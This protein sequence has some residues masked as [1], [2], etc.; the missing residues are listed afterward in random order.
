MRLDALWPI[1]Y[2]AAGPASMTS[3]TISVFRV[4]SVIYALV[5]V[6]VSSWPVIKIPDLGVSWGDKIAHFSQY[7]V[8]A[9][10]VAGGWARQGGW[11]AW[12]EQWR[13]VAFLIAFA[14]I[15][16]I[17]QVWIPRRAASAMD[18]TAD[19]LGILVGF[20]LGLLLWWRSK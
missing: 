14:A 17:H 15:D 10:L 8:F 18:W 6:A 12:R 2:F 13:P 7:A 3:R 9:C 16:E 19:S 11:A 4:L 20:G 5:V 1:D